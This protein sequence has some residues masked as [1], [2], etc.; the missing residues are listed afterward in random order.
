MK[1]ANC[2]QA[3]TALACLLLGATALAQPSTLEYPARR[4]TYVAKSEGPPKRIA[5][6]TQSD[7]VAAEETSL[8]PQ[9]DPATDGEDGYQ[10]FS[11]PSSS[12]DSSWGSDGG[13][14][15]E[16]DFCD[17][18]CDCGQCA[19]CC[20]GCLGGFWFGGVDY[21]LFRPR[22]S[23][24][25]AAI[26]RQETTTPGFP[27]TSTLSDTVIEYPWDY[28]SG[29]R[30][31]A[32]YRLIEWGGE[33]QV[34]YW[35]MSSDSKVVTEGPADTLT[36]NPFIFGNL[37][38]NPGNGQFLS[39]QTGVTANIFD[40]D[41]TKAISLGGP[42]EPYM[43]GPPRWDLRFF[44]GARAGD[45][46]RYNNNEVFNPDGTGVSFGNVGARF[47]GGGPRIGFQSRRY[48]GQNGFW[49]VYAKGAGSLLIGEF[50][51][52]RT[53]RVPSDGTTP[54]QLTTESN[55]GTRTIP[56]TDI[57]LGLSWQ[58]APYT[59]V[60]VGYFWQ[61][62]WDLG[63]GEGLCCASNFGALDTS[64]ILGF[65]GLFVRGEMMF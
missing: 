56:V 33:F 58:P 2:A 40:M 36:N 37:N 15:C 48:L 18:C 21:L 12:G 23:N 3:V 61:A 20:R 5:L 55:L 51:M 63:Q 7:E 44:G 9:A 11:D 19:E 52:N 17:D 49:S 30:V 57:E 35:R 31:N 34:S 28:Q 25:V 60:S 10:L 26:R 62:W 6:L 8:E 16:A 43:P 64:N 39:A 22:L 45:I 24:G 47:T 1:I 38:N 27:P 29:F 53:L 59:F 65:D 13:T 50:R 41:F 32:G 4:V 42:P 14:G 54:N 46:I